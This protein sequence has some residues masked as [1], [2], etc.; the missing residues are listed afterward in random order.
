LPDR[1]HPAA[2]R[3]AAPE[4]KVRIAYQ[5]FVPVH[6]GRRPC[7]R[8]GKRRDGRTGRTGTIAADMGVFRPELAVELPL[9]TGL[10]RDLC[11]GGGCRERRPY[12]QHHRFSV[13]VH[14]LLL[15]LRD[16]SG[17]HPKISSPGVDRRCADVP[18]CRTIIVATEHL[19]RKLPRDRCAVNEM[20][21][22]QRKR[23]QDRLDW[24]SARTLT[25]Y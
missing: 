7:G 23:T 6:Q 14:P 19:R 5:H 24:I 25:T 16:I 10:A 1:L 9:R 18:S 13:E 17:L 3:P 21:G 4:S 15:L 8:G 22:W 11:V 2:Q 20:Q 12:R